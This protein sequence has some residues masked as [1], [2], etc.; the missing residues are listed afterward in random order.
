MN[1]PDQPTC[2]ALARAGWKWETYFRYCPVP[3]M[4]KLRGNEWCLAIR[5]EPSACPGLPCPSIGE[6]RERLTWDNFIA[7]FNLVIWP[8]LKLKKSTEH[9]W[10]QF[11]RWFYEVTAD[12]NALAKIWLW[13][14]KEKPCTT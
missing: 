13:A 7:Y 9:V 11:A 8:E 12:A 5:C 4:E 2:E 10:L 1:H 6:L 3:G 14:Q